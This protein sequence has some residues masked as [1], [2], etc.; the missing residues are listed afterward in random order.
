MKRNKKH[1]IDTKVVANT[2]PLQLKCTW[3]HS[4]KINVYSENWPNHKKNTF[5]GLRERI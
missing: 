3:Q 2:S 1:N 4:I 5:S